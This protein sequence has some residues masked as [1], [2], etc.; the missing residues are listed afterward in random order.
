MAAIH[1]NY[2]FRKFTVQ[3]QKKKVSHA[4]MRGVNL[5]RIFL[6][7]SE[8][9]VKIISHRQNVKSFLT[10]GPMSLTFF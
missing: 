10:R 4:L 6:A 8:F 1:L 5:G 7:E 2:R 9:L 3:Q